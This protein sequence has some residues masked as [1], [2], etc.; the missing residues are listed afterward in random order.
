[1]FRTTM[2]AI[3]AVLA[4]QTQASLANHISEAQ[5]IAAF[6]A[7]QAQ[8]AA[9]DVEIADQQEQIDA[10]FD[11]IAQLHPANK[12]AFITSTF[13]QGALLGG[14]AG[15]DA[16]CQASADDAGLI[17]IFMAWLADDTGSPD[18]RFTRSL[19]PYVTTGEAPDGG[20]RV[21]DDWTDLTTC[22]GTD[23]FDCLKHAIDRDEFGASRAGI[24]YWSNVNTDGTN[25]SVEHCSNW[26]GFGGPRG[27]GLLGS[28]NF[29][30]A[31]WTVAD[32]PGDFFTS[33]GVGITLLC[34][35]Q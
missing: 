18:T 5:A 8:V 25:A 32:P 7:L 1:M 13:Q 6:Q 19:A 35:E 17:G 20:D 31:R 2:L 16:I 22:D 15:A 24:A 12:I 11:L 3:V 26:M 23:P 27:V 21:A 33:C 10:L 34:F 28:S 4:L 14:L 29:I 9:Q 30:D